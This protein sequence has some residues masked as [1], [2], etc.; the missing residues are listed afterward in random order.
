MFYELSERIWRACPAVIS[1]SHWI[2][3]STPK[4]KT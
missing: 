1:I 3:T 2:D 4:E